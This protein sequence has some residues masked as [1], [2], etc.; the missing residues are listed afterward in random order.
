MHGVAVSV[1]EFRFDQAPRTPEGSSDVQGGG[2][3]E[4]IYCSR[5]RH[6]DKQ[7]GT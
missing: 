1:T 7:W 5:C 6:D 4:T 3:S 2:N